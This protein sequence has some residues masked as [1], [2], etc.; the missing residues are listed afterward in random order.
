[1]AMGH[2]VAMIDIANNI[3]VE[4]SVVEV[5]DTTVDIEVAM[6]ERGW[7]MALLTLT[8][9]VGAVYPSF[10]P[11]V[12]FFDPRV[13]SSAVHAPYVLVVFLGRMF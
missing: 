7:W 9:V 12:L 6:D 10:V 2:P 5:E 3:A 13:L 8:P 11:V 1:M 4:D